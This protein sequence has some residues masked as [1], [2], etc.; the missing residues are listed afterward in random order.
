MTRTE[1]SG[2]TVKINQDGAIPIHKDHAG[3][4]GKSWYDL[5]ENQG[6]GTS[7]T[8]EYHFCHLPKYDYAG[9]VMNYQAVEIWV[10]G[11]GDP[12]NLA[13]YDY[14]EGGIRKSLAALWADY[15][16][17]YTKNE[18]VVGAQ[19]TND[20]QT[21][22]ITNRLTA[23]KNIHWHKQWN[24]NYNYDSQ[25]R[26][27]IYLDI[28]RRAMHQAVNWKNMRMITS[29]HIR[30]L[31]RI[32]IHP[33]VRDIIGSQTFMMSISMTPRD[34][35]GITTQKRRQR[36]TNPSLITRRSSI[37]DGPMKMILLQKKIWVQNQIRLRMLVSRYS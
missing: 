28:Y 8:A 4:A 11:N 16:S 21:V 37:H 3:T 34:M 29:G 10:D 36:W 19:H 24:D 7:Q 15:Q 5:L 6:S 32:R 17:A 25:L 9:A 14:V 13:K 23:V 22:E 30:M 35:S 26:P 27:D 12:A 1:A 20:S 18:Y 31:L 2:D 33:S